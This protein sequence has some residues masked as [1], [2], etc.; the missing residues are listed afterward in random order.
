MHSVHLPYNC[1]YHD[2]GCPVL[3]PAS[4]MAKH[5]KEDAK[6]HLKLV[7]RVLTVEQRE[8]DM[9]KEAMTCAQSRCRKIELENASLRR[10]IDGIKSR[11]EASNLSPTQ[12]ELFLRILEMDAKAMD[13]CE[14]LYKKKLRTASASAAGLELSAEAELM[15]ELRVK[16]RELEE[17][18]E[19]AKNELRKLKEKLEKRRPVES[20]EDV[21]SEPPVYV[22]G[23]PISMRDGEPK[24]LG[25]MSQKFP[26]T[27]MS[28]NRGINS[29]LAKMFW[30]LT[31]AQSRKPTEPKRSSSEEILRVVERHHRKQKKIQMIHKA[32]DKMAGRE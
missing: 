9:R 19:I 17:E 29:S 15:T 7:L 26:T 2:V 31:R 10:R 16:L 13:S 5:L 14:E 3:L 22:M 18:N 1:K 6:S 11:I 23:F 28:L 12:Y 32:L 20:K 4:A 27:N 25:E 30:N 21:P 24:L 8:N